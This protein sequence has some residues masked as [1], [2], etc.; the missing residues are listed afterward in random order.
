MNSFHILLTI[1]MEITQHGNTRKEEH[2]ED[3]MAG[4][5]CAFI[6]CLFSISVISSW[7]TLPFSSFWDLEK[8]ACHT[9]EI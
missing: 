5:A 2:T 7:F 8:N 3:L 1:I 4:S 6:G 9:V